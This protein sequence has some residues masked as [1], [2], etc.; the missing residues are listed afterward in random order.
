MQRDSERQAKIE[1]LEQPQTTDANA[2][3]VKGGAVR[4]F[5][6][7][8]IGITLGKDVSIPITKM[9]EI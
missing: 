8:E 3:E 6:I 5:I 2:E 4:P 9:P 7:D 1:D